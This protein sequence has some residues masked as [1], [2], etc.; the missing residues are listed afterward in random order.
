MVGVN[1]LISIIP[2]PT[3]QRWSISIRHIEVGICAIPFA[4]LCSLSYR[5][6]YIDCPM[7]GIIVWPKSIIPERFSIR[8]GSLEIK[9]PIPR[10]VRRKIDLIISILALYLPDIIKGFY[11]NYGA[12]DSGFIIFNLRITARTRISTTH[13]EISIISISHN[14]IITSIGFAIHEGADTFG[15]G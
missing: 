5:L 6:I 9:I 8:S 7:R 12:V 10:V 4:V 13:N 3:T 15:S 14:A 2:T 1:G 11:L